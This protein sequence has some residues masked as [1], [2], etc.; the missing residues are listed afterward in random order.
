VSTK[1]TTS[2][3]A[4]QP[5]KTRFASLK[6]KSEAEGIPYTSARDAAARGEFPVMKIGRNEKYARSYVEQ[7][8][9]E[10]WIE[11]RKRA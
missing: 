4:S 10:Q 2:H 1:N 11:S 6:R 7:R 3:T 8:D 5:S 9:W